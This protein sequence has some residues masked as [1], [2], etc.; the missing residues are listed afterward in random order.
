MYEFDGFVCDSD[1]TVRIHVNRSVVSFYPD[2]FLY[3]HKSVYAQ[4]ARLEYTISLSPRTG[5][6]CQCGA[7]SLAYTEQPHKLNPAIHSESSFP[8]SNRKLF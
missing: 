7:R 1:E 6:F 4:I 3:S 8:R 5:P 2:P